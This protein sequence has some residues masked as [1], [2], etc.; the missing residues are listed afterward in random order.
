[1]NYEP[2]DYNKYKAGR[3]AVTRDGRVPEQLTGIK[4][5]IGLVIVGTVDG[6]LETWGEG[7]N[8]HYDVDM[9]NCL[10]LFLLPDIKEVWVA[11]DTLHNKYFIYANE[12]EL[13]D[14]LLMAKAANSDN[15]KYLKKAK[16]IIYG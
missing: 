12:K 9:K 5:T 1:M 13:D 8:Y 7:G 10:D 14:V 15:E 2:F 6:V 16:L 4:A 3:K 11:V